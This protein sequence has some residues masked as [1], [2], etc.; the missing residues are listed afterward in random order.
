MNS[1]INENLEV[2]TY[3]LFSHLDKNN[4]MTIYVLDVIQ[5]LK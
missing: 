4:E 2:I 5:L 3:R 1:A